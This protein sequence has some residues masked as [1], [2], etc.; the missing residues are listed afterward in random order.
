MQRFY[1]SSLNSCRLFCCYLLLV[2]CFA[3]AT[4]MGLLLATYQLRKHKKAAQHTCK[5]GKGLFPK[6]GKATMC[7]IDTDVDTDHSKCCAR[8]TSGMEGQSSNENNSASRMPTR[9]TTNED[10]EKVMM[11]RLKKVTKRVNK[12]D[13]DTEYGEERK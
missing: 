10:S 12:S 8:N 11:R 7:V 1:P 2:I 3:L 6:H 4:P 13:M 9:T 5:R